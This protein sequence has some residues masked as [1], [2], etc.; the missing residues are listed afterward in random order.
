LHPIELVNRIRTGKMQS[1]AFEIQLKECFF[2]GACSAV[3]P[4]DIPL[5]DIIREE[6]QS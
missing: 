6:R 3:C 2:C 1:K 5:A 4:S